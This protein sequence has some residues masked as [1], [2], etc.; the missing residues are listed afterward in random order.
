MCLDRLT[1]GPDETEGIAYKVVRRNG[2]TFRPVLMGG[3][4]LRRRRWESDAHDV[5]LHADS[6]VPYRTGFHLLTA[7][8]AAQRVASAL[9]CSYDDIALRMCVVRVKYRRV[10]ARGPQCVW[11]VDAHCIVA[12]EIMVVDEVPLR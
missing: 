8:R 1:S 3:R 6:G 4:K 7:K 2:K 12:R 9:R 11:G 10:S 5:S